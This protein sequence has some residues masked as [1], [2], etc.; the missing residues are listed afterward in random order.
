MMIYSKKTLEMYDEAIFLDLF[1]IMINRILV[2]VYKR[3]DIY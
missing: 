3:F 1:S 2:F